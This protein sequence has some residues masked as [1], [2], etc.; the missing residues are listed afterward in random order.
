MH[1]Y[2]I[3]IHIY[4]FSVQ[5]NLLTPIFIEIRNPAIL[6]KLLKTYLKGQFINI[7]GFCLK[8]EDLILEANKIKERFL[9]ERLSERT[10]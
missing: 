5:L 6:F 7:R 3:Y 10:D 2:N 8:Y 1:I 4:I 9:E